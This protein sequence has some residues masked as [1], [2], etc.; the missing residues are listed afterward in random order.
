[1]GEHTNTLAFNIVAWATG[2][3]MIALTMVLIYA[4]LFEPASAALG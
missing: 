3:V 4:A 2:I 1:M